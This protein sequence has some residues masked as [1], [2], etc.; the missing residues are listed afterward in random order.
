MGEWERRVRRIPDVPLMKSFYHRQ[1][2][3]STSRRDKK[4]WRVGWGI[5][6]KTPRRVVFIHHYIQ[7]RLALVNV[8][9]KTKTG[10][11]TSPDLAT[12]WDENQR[13]WL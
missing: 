13:L 6:S 5:F 11:Q 9:L 12:G 7:Q 1:I 3:A 10:H 2:A 4:V 8:P